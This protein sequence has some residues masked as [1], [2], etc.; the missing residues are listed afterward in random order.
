MCLEVRGELARMNSLF[1][2]FVSWG[3]NSGL[4]A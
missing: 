1:A 4:W 3:L 2:P